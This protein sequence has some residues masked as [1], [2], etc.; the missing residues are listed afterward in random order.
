MLYLP[1]IYT[2]SIYEQL[3]ENDIFGLDDISNLIPQTNLT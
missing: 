1:M 2:T 3:A